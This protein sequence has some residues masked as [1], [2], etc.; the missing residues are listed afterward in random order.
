MRCISQMILR[1]YKVTEKDLIISVYWPLETH[2]DVVNL[3]R[4][5]VWQRL[6]RALLS[7]GK[8]K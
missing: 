2:R 5:I 1:R 4:V 7:Y 6:R 8:W 3:G